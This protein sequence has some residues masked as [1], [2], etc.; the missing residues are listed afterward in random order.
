MYPEHHLDAQDLSVAKSGVV[1]RVISQVWT[2]NA[3]LRMPRTCSPVVER[4]GLRNGEFMLGFR[5]K[6]RSKL[7]SLNE[8]SI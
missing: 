4:L 8:E 6:L 5:N 2:S 1:T 7:L 3:R